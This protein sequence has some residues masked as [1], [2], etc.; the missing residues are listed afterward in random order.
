[1]LLRV[2]D[3]IWLFWL[4]VQGESVLWLQ[5]QPRDATMFLILKI[6]VLI[7]PPYAQQTMKRIRC[8]FHQR[9]HKDDSGER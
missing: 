6:E 2:L 1:M 8:Q 5:F 3:V 4:S 9:Y 7:I